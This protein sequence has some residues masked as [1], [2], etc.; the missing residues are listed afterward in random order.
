MALTFSEPAGRRMSTGRRA[1]SSSPYPGHDMT[2]TRPSDYP[3]PPR[4]PSRS[5]EANPDP[6]LDDI[7]H[8]CCSDLDCLTNSPQDERM[9]L[10]VQDA[11][12]QPLLG[13]QNPRSSRRWTLLAGLV[14][15]LVVGGVITCGVATMHTESED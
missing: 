14:L 5:K 10:P 13:S 2:C 9:P 4:R 11:E 15:V 6:F 8:Q 12:R 3:S 1:S 7:T